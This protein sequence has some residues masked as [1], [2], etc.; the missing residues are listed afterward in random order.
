MQTRTPLD[1]RGSNGTDTTLASN[2]TTQTQNSRETNINP[3]TT[4]DVAK[5]F[6]PDNKN[7]INNNTPSNTNT[8][9]FYNSWGDN[10]PMTKQPHT[11]HMALQNFGGWPQWNNRQNKQIFR[12][13][14]NKK[15]I[16]IYLTIKNNV[17]WHQIP[18]MQ[19]L[20]E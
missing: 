5:Q 1:T 9:S 2:P 7:E 20:H 13:H 18:P 6:N 8:N 19:Y 4:T 16:E 15:N 14:L 10:L 3:T 17:V 11:V 12:Q